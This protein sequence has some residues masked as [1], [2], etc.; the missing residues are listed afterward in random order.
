MRIK[1]NST[2]FDFPTS[3]SAM[4]L[5]QRIDFQNEH[6]NT[7]DAMLAS[8]L[9]MPDDPIRDLELAQYQFE[10]MFSTFAFFSG[11]TV[12]ALKA[13]E[14]INEISAIYFASMATIM[15][16]EQAL[17]IRG[18]YEWKGETWELAAPEL[19]QGS[20]M[21]F[22]EF[23]DSKQ[24]IKNMID[25][26]QGKWEQMAALC[27]IYLRRA[28]EAYQP[29]FMY[30]GSERRELMRS[31]PLDIALEVGFFLTGSLNSF[32]NI[33]PFS[34]PAAFVPMPGSAQPITSDMAG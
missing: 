3:L 32:L 7:L 34:N 21:T 24:I 1:I 4:T 27:A 19:R 15:E 25:L 30:D 12:E 31:L 20:N 11:A 28:G 33:S 29:E 14:F 17:S 6:G 18:K 26:G 23:I 16:D 2:E 8:I 10:K 13:S 5:G 9:E 22:G